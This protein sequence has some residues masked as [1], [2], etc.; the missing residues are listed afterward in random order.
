MFPGEYV[1]HVI[2]HPDLLAVHSSHCRDFDM[3]RLPLTHCPSPIADVE[4]TTR[5]AIQASRSASR[6]LTARPA[7]TKSGPLPWSRSLSSV[8]SLR[9]NRVAASRCVSSRTMWSPSSCRGATRTGGGARL[10]SPISARLSGHRIQEIL[11][12][13][14]YSTEFRDIT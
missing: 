13:I 10:K 14:L 9:R 5:A 12:S 6:Y 4:E 8:R 3:P 1:G 7:L 2:R 11:Q